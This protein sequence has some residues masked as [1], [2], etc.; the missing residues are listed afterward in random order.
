MVRFNL[1]VD[2]GLDLE[3]TVVNGS[4]AQI[5]HRRRRLVRVGRVARFGAANRMLQ[6]EH[7]LRLKE[8]DVAQGQAAQLVRHVAAAALALAERRLRRN[9]AHVRARHV[10]HLRPHEV[11]DALLVE[12]EV[13][14]RSVH[15]SRRAR[16]LVRQ[17]NGARVICD[18]RK[19]NQVRALT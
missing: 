3:R 19:A 10:R 11:V 2:S 7:V 9:V 1:K 18:T 17:T 12:A 5:Q 13:A 15:S 4:A 16:A 14:R 8:F 6:L